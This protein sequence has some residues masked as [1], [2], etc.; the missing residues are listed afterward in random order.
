MGSN[1]EASDLVELRQRVFHGDE[2]GGAGNA[3]RRPKIGDSAAL[4]GGLQFYTKNFCSLVLAFLVGDFLNSIILARRKVYR[5]GPS[6]LE[7]GILS[8]VC[9]PGRRFL[10]VF[11]RWR[12][13]GR[14]RGNII[15][16]ILITHYSLKVGIEV[17]G[18][19]VSYRLV[20]FSNE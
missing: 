6:F 17:L 3:G 12:S 2:L 4:R 10:A 13:L 7:A 16:T 9:R 5:S 1:D 20:T 14:G 19:P 18:V 8:T 15:W 11:I